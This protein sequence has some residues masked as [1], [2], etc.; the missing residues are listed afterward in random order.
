[1]SGVVVRVFD[2]CDQPDAVRHAP[3]L[4]DLALA[5]MV[6]VPG[7]FSGRL[8]IDFATAYARNP[9]PKPW[10]SGSLAVAFRLIYLMLARVLS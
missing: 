6:W 3:Q 9:S 1:M 4:G 2:V 5:E 7:T 8:I 10:S